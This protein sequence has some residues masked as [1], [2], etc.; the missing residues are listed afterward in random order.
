MGNVYA[1][2][3]VSHK[4][5]AESGL[6]ERA[7][8]DVIRRHYKQVR[9]EFGVRWGK[10]KYPKNQ[11]MGF[12]VDLAQSAWKKKIHE[13]PAGSRLLKAVQPGDHV[14]FYS[15][16]R[17]FRSVLDYAFTI[18][19]WVDRGIS[20][21]FVMDG[22]LD[23]TTANGKMMANIIAAFAQWRSDMISERTKEAKALIKDGLIEPRKKRKRPLPSGASENRED[24]LLGRYNFLLSKPKPE[25][26]PGRVFTYARISYMDEKRLRKD[27]SI[28]LAAQKRKTKAYADRLVRDRENLEFGDHFEDAGVSAFRQKL[29]KRANGSKMNEVLKEGDH[30][31]ITRVDRCWRNVRDMLETVEDWR[32]RGI[33]CHFADMRMDTSSS[34]GDLFLHVMCLMAE[35]ESKMIARSTKSAVDRLK[36]DG[37]RHNNDNPFGF[38]SVQADGKVYLVPDEDKLWK[39]WHFTLMHNHGMS[40]EKISDWMEE[41]QA[42]VDGRRVIPISGWHIAPQRLKLADHFDV[43][44]CVWKR[45]HLDGTIYRYWSKK[46]VQVAIEG[47][48]RALEIINRSKDHKPSRSGRS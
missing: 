10:E 21:H 33:T 25:S 40:F 1:Y 15:L 48:P 23:I 26:I 18:P 5:S 43:K 41:H 38:K 9:D 27:E 32:G 45:S 19:R 34:D 35:L 14:I 36:A 29:R 22:A 11:Q 37:R 30:V 47:L 4:D 28:S 44:K 31:V 6:S 20:V 3:R 16:D 24:F 12:F 13:R 17:G 8:K 7:Q 46:S 39:A 42:K 2:V